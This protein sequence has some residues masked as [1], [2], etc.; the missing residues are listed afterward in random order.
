MRHPIRR[1]LHPRSI[2]SSVPTPRDLWPV[3]AE[4]RNA[5]LPRFLATLYSLGHSRHDRIL[6]VTCADVRTVLA[7]P[8]G[9]THGMAIPCSK[10]RYGNNIP[11]LLCAASSLGAARGSGCGE[12][13][14]LGRLK[15]K[16]YL[17]SEAEKFGVNFNPSSVISVPLAFSF[18]SVSHGL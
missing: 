6:T 9:G 2:P 3:L 4:R 11:R 17:S 15:G 7:L 12:K 5:S 10:L 16:N 18:L 8:V 13:S 1:G 14:I